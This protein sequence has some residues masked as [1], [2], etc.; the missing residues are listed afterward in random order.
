[1]RA[2][3]VEFSYTDRPFMAGIDFDVKPGMR[4]AVVGP[5]GCGKTTL[6]NLF[7][8]FYETNAGTITVDG[9]LLYTSKDKKKGKSSCGC[10][11]GSCPMAG[12]C[13]SKK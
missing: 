9:C 12:S 10:K 4:V 11:C 2:D 5:T 1:M 6:I 13:H 8:R 7:M 3:G